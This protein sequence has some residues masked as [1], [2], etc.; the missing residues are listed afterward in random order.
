MNKINKVLIINAYSY[1]NRGDSGII[2]AMIDIIRKSYKNADIS[3]MSQYHEQNIE[4][5]NKMN[6]KSV[7]P[8]WDI[9]NTK[10]FLN[11]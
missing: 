4:Y 10:G 6:V 8:V 9:I 3:V 1:K 2:V 7:P 5:Y 11:K